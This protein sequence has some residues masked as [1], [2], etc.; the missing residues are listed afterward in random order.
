MPNILT[1]DPV[2]LVLFAGVLLGTG[3]AA[4]V[5]AG[6]LGVGGGIVIVPVLFNLFP[7]LGIDDAVRM[8][9]AVGTSLATIIP[10][11]IMSMRAHHKKAAVDWS[12]LKSWAPAIAVGVLAGTVLGA[13]AKGWALTAVFATVAVLVSLNMAF[14]KEG[15]IVAERLPRG[16]IKQAMGAVIGL[17]SVMMGIGGGTLTV[18]TLSAFNYPIRRAVGSASA[19]GLIIAVPGTIGFITSGLGVAN[20]PPFS[21][22]Y[23]NVIGFAL[24]VPATMTAAPWGAKIAHAIQPA[25]LRKAFALFLFLTSAR[26][27]WSLL[28]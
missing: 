18:P 4:G 28:G 8:H 6:L 21:L 7:L 22:G 24:I 27:F 3:L 26:M 2:F 23:A 5:L 25:I 1:A 9:L 11:S 19:I 13:H 20:L 14:R 17:F 10:T 12:L 15:M 16:M